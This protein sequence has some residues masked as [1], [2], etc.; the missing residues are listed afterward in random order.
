MQHR[1][2]LLLALAALAA[3]EPGPTST[4]TPCDDP[5]PLTLAY[6]TAD[7]PT[8][9]A[10]GDDGDCGFGK[11]F[12][13]AY[14]ISCHDS[15]LTRSMRNGAPLFHDF[16]T[17]LGVLKTPDHIDQQAGVGPDASNTF[18]PPERC[19][20]QAGGPLDRACLQPTTAEREKLA[21]W[22]ACERDRE[23]A[24]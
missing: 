3:C 8:C 23:H 17:L 18:M 16:E 9:V 6:A 1:L 4:G 21:K 11:R 13:D 19:P 5:D 15:K 2:H 24:F 14:C 10:S 7:V 22:I 20:T 12:M